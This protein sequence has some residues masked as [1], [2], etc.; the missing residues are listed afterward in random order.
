M[1]ELR[2]GDLHLEGVE[3][4]LGELLMTAPG[5]QA[6]LAQHR[7]ARQA[8]RTLGA[9]GEAIRHCEPGSE[10]HSDYK[11]RIRAFEEKERLATNELHMLLTALLDN[12]VR[13]TLWAACTSGA[14]SGAMCPRHR[15]DP[16]L[17]E[18]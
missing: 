10:K 13:D 6:I 11:Q 4:L 9:L 5:H 14:C 2:D 8:A 18:P 3:Y 17:K 16:K 15:H 12:T 7:E 1:L